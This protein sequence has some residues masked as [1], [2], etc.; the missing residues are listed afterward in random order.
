MWHEVE[1]V[2]GAEGGA[3]GGG[4]YQD[5]EGVWREEQEVAAEETGGGGMA[6]SGD[7]G[8]GADLTTAGLATADEPAA[9]SS[10]SDA[11]TSSAT[12]PPPSPGE[13]AKEVK[14][15]NGDC[16]EQCSWYT[17]GQASPLG[18]PRAMPRGAQGPAHSWDSPGKSVTPRFYTEASSVKCFHGEGR[19]PCGL[20]PLARL[21]PP[22]PP[23]PPPPAPPRPWRSDPPGEPQE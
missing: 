13:E 7:G 17:R 22:P 5:T 23:P 19:L 10:E 14:D 16:G 6:E 20:L 8:S 1:E 9:V 3:G 21:A 18:S 4:W 2:G 15:P 11:T 12:V